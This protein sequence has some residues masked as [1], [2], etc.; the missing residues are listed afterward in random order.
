MKKVLVILFA[1][2]GLIACPQAEAQVNA[3]QPSTA[4]MVST[5]VGLT[6]IKSSIPV[7]KQRVARSLVLRL[8]TLHRLDRSGAQE[9]MQALK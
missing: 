8:N 3:P 7:R 1:V 4:A 6:D 9:P 5:V 2:T